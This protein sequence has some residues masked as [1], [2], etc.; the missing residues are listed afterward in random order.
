MQRETSET[1]N[2]SRL[3]YQLGNTSARDFLV[4]LAIKKRKY[5]ATLVVE[6]ISV[7]R[8]AINHSPAWDEI[9]YR[10]VNDIPSNTICIPP[11][12]ISSATCTGNCAILILASGIYYP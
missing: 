7:Q 10:V 2:R 12:S 6:C 5:Y 1:N 11:E 9:R 8:T 3:I 4:E